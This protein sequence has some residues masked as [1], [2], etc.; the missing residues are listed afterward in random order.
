MHSCPSDLEDFFQRYRRELS[1]FTGIDKGID[2]QPIC[3]LSCDHDE[4]EIAPGQFVA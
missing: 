4:R 3:P 2:T 1:I